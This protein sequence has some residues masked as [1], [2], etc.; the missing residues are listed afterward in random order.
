MREEILTLDCP[1]CGANFKSLLQVDRDSFES[2]HVERKVE[3]CPSCYRASHFD[4][5]DY[6]FRE[7]PEGPAK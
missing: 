1:K 5:A 6:R 2:L 3:M 7:G 4:K